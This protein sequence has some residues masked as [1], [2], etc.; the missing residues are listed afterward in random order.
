MLSILAAR[1]QP[2]ACYEQYYGLAQRPF[3]LTP[4]QRFRYPAR[5]FRQALEEIRHAL[6]RR[7]GLVVVTGD[8]G[9][10]KTMLCRTLL[11]ELDTPVCVS[12]VLDP[13]LS[14]DDLLCHVLR[15]FGVLGSDYRLP[16]NARHTPGRH[17]LATALQHFLLSLVPL[18]SYAVIV[19]DE[20]QHVG[21]DVL[22]QLR[23]LLNYETDE[24]KLLQVVLVG[25]PGLD[26]LLERPAMRQLAQR[27]ARRC[28]LQ[29][30]GPHEVKRYIERRVRVAQR[31]ALD[32]DGTGCGHLDAHDGR[33][34]G[35]VSFTPSASAAVAT[36]SQGIPR[37]VNLV[38]DHALDIAFERR[39]H[40]VDRRIVR[41]AGRRV[42]ATIP[43]M[44]RPRSRTRTAALAAAAIVL[45]SAPAVWT[46]A[47]IS[48][49]QAGAPAPVSSAAPAPRESTGAVVLASS[50]APGARFKQ[51]RLERSADRVSLVVEMDT[52]P[53]KV[54]THTDGRTMLE[55]EVGPVAGPAHGQELTP[56]AGMPFVEH[57]SVDAY[58][59]ANQ[60][61]F[62]RARV[63]L[64]GA[65]RTNV[66][67]VGS[68]VY[69]D[70]DASE[71]PRRTPA[72]RGDS[73]HERVAARPSEL[74][75]Y[76]EASGPIVARLTE[77]G[78]FLVSASA[79]PAPD[80]L[81]A[82]AETLHDVSESLRVID[83]PGAAAPAHTLLNSAVSLAA[84]AVTPEFDGD[85]VAQAHRAL[86]LVDAARA[87]IP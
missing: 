47:S 76:R 66:R 64:L 32:G 16:V 12:I 72:P 58:E 39:T 33:V 23:L 15:D 41:A 49:A 68:R 57:V 26:H 60:D 37:L 48:S 53:Q 21:A 4:D 14:I 85:R 74:V 22:E 61:R 1:P 31:L 29:P 81:H 24:S 7:E 75:R 77:I 65:P 28:V 86:A 73:P 35:R 79:T 17:E 43:S 46:W 34:S 59:G 87:Q 55:V 56:S 45:A 25:Q 50:L 10:G 5:S 71:A 19:I 52:E 8:S 62:I 84:R 11:Q 44:R 82:V 42:M 38:C 40:T 36:L 2:T 69:V 30:L 6:H 67:V 9:T 54:V 63:T 13:R 70:F 27:V 83:V 18:G 3:G 51:V 78:P 20:A 80:V